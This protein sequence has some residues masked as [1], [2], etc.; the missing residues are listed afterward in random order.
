MREIEFRGKYHLIETDEWIWIYGCN[1]WGEIVDEE[2]DHWRVDESTI[3]QYTGLKDKNG[4]KIYEG[5]VLKFSWD[6]IG[7]RVEFYGV[8]RFCE[9]GA[10]FRYWE[11]R[12][13]VWSTFCSFKSKE[14]E[15]VG[16]IFDNLEF[17]KKFGETYREAK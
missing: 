4:V 17:E 3:G 1:D 14:M 9:V 6:S 11:E 7:E 10:A 15:V 5:D 16:N 8:V 2:D 12:F 13:K